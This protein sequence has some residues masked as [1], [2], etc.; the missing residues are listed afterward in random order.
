M[1]NPLLNDRTWNGAANDPGWAAPDP[2]TRA[3]P[4]TDGPISGW[5]SR[6]MTVGGTITATGVL[7]VILLAAA[8]VGWQSVP[9]TRA[10]CAA[11]RA[12]A[13][14]GVLVGFACVI[15]IYFRPMWATR[16]GAP[17]TPSPKASSSAS[18]PGLRDLPGRHRSAGGRRH[19]RCLRRHAGAVS[20]QDHQGHRPIPHRRHHGH[21]RPDGVLPL[22]VHHP[23]VRWRRLASCSRRAV[24]HRLQR[25]RR[26]S[27]GNEPGARLRLHRARRQAGSAQGHGVVRRVGV[28]SSPSC[29][30][31]SRCFVCS[32]NSSATD[33]A[34]RP[35]S[36]QEAQ[37]GVVERCWGLLLRPVAG[38]VD[39][40]R[41]A[42]VGQQ[43]PHPLDA[44]RVH[45]VDDV[46]G[47]ADE[48]RSACQPVGR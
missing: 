25:L 12:L 48:V 35:T 46:V 39:N 29:G 4:I 34:R 2:T 1:P 21:A 32:A 47:A 36:C 38:A 8:V 43:V 42:E 40:R 44:R 20:H 7:L 17:S 27:G 33:S 30:C 10:R 3:T 18:S 14:V 9:T 26:R 24:R 15:A 19:A 23:P 37:Q 41:A 13:L 16:A 28:W 31:T 5:Q 6:V 22:L 11:S 45:D